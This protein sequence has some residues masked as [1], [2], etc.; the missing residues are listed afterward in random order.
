S[1]AAD[2][3]VS[4]SARLE[5]YARVGKNVL[6]EGRRGVGK[7]SLVLEVARKL[8]LRLAYF[9]APTL[10]PWADLVGVPVPQDGRLVFL[11]PAHVSEAEFLFLDELNRAHPKVQNAILELTLFRSLNG[12]RLERLRTVWAAINPPDGEYQ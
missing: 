9:S 5:E 11:R 7:T 3:F 10:D 2:P 1:G 12:E 6:L 4:I 8:G